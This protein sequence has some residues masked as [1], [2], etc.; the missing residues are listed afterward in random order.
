MRLC[1]RVY[2]VYHYVMVVICMRPVDVYGF[3]VKHLVIFFMSVNFYLQ[4][5]KNIFQG[6]GHPAVYQ[7]PGMYCP[8]YIIRK[9]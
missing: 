9:I 6:S 4:R 1:M 5:N 3:L 7:C 8:D 2:N